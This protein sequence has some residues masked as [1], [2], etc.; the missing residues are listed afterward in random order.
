MVKCL[1]HL[2]LFYNVVVCLIVGL[3]FDP[4]TWMF[5]NDIFSDLV[6]DQDDDHEG[7]GRQPPHELQWVHVQA[8]VEAWCVAE[9]SRQACLEEKTE[10]QHVIGHSLLE[11]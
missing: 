2:L 6:V 5:P 11:E 8:L 9:R 7:H 10:I 3:L 1:A 4:A